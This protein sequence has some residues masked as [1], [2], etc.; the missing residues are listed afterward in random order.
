M[1]I[2]HV[3]THRIDG[4]MFIVIFSSILTCLFVALKLGVKGFELNWFQVLSPS[5]VTLAIIMLAYSIAYP[6]IKEK[7]IKEKVENVK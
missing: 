1:V 7:E 5:W 4:S 3:H 2:N 6:K